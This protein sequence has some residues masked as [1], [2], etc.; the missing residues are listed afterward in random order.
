[1]QV[2]IDIPDE[3]AESLQ[4]DGH[5][6]SRKALEALVVEAYRNEVITRY[7]VG[8]ILGLRSRFAVD[9]FL[10]RSNIY[11]HYNETDLDDDRKTLEHLRQEGKLKI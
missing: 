9:A 2:I 7:Q 1:M 10:K 11:L 3:F 8:Q 6:L 5:D 4:R